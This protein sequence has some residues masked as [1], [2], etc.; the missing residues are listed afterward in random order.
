MLAANTI[1]KNQFLF[2]H[3]NK[4]ILKCVTLYNVFGYVIFMCS[5]INNIIICILFTIASSC[6]YYQILYIPN[7][8]IRKKKRH[9]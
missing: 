5:C 4:L 9:Y 1:K 3:K 7:Y 8:S 6:V 2:L